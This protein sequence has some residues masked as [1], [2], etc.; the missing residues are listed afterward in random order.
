MCIFTL[1]AIILH[2]LEERSTL[3]VVLSGVFTGLGIFIVF[4]GTVAVLMLTQPTKTVDENM[5]RPASFVT[6]VGR[7]FGVRNLS[8]PA[9]VMT[10]SELPDMGSYH[11][12]Y[13]YGAN[14]ANLRKATLVVADG[15]KVGLYDHN[16]ELMKVEKK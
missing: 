1:A 10:A 3:F 2:C 13:T 16:G 7:E 6:Q 12:V 14:D 11:C 15:N 8:C 4:L 5:P 9:K